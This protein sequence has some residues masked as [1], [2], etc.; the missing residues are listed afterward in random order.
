VHLALVCGTSLQQGVHV[1][2][3]G[4]IASFVSA[5]LAV[6]LHEE[7]KNTTKIFSEK[8]SKISKKGRRVLRR[9]F[10]SS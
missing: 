3:K 1:G 7:L 5:F 4:L 9:V 10:F 6:S 2:G 8:I